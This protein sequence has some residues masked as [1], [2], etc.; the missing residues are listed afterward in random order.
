MRKFTNLKASVAPMVLGI[1]MVSAPAFAQDQDAQEADAVEQNTIIVTGSRISNPN[2]EL[3]SPVGVVTSEELELRQTNTAEQFLRELPSAIPSVGSAVN[4][5][6]GGSFFVN[7]RG[8]GSVRNLVLLDGRRFVP[9]DTTGRVDLNN[10]PLAVIERTDVLTGGATT[11]YGADAI[12]G[13]VNFITKRD[14]AGIE[15]NASQQITEQGDGNVFRTDL[16]IGANFDD[17]RGNVVLSVGYQDQDPV[18]QGDRSFGADNVGSFTGRASGSSNAV[19]ANI[20]F[21]ALRDPTSVCDMAL[22][23]VA[24]NCPLVV[25]SVNPANNGRRTTYNGFGFTPNIARQ[26]NQTGTDLEASFNP[27]PFNF[28]PFNLYQTPFE[29]FNIFGSARYEINENVELYS[30]AVFSKNTVA[31]KIAPGGSFFNVYQLNLN[32]P[33]IP[34]A[35]AQRFGNGLG[36]FGAAYTAARTTPFG[37]TLADGSANP[38]YVTFSSQVRRRTVEVGTRDSEYTSTLFNLVVGARGAI[39]D[40]IN[41][42]ISAT[43]GESERIQRQSG[44]ARFNRLQNSLLSLP[45]GQCVSGSGD[46]CAPINLFGAEGNLGPQA[47]QDYV[48]NLTQ[49]VITGT[50]IATV[51]GNITGDLGFGFSETPIQFAVGGEYRAFTATRLS[52]EASQTPG[53][54]V[55]GGGAAPDINGSYDVYDAFGELSI[56]VFEGESFAESL[57]IDLGAR[58]SDYSTAGTEFTWKAGGSWEVIPG[59]TFRGNYQRSSR[60]PNIGE[61]FTPVSTGLSNLANDP[62]QG[63]VAPTGN[64]LAACLAQLPAGSPGIAAITAG[65]L[66][67]PAAGQINVTTG[68]NLNLGTETAKTWTVGVAFQPDAVPGLSVTV[69]YFNIDI[70]GAISAPTPGDAIA[71]CFNAPSAA[72]PFC[73][74]QFISRNPFTGGI[75]GDPASTKG[76]I[77]QQSNLGA[78]A[79]DGIDLSVRYKT[80]LTDMIGLALSFDGTWTNSQTFQASPTSINRECVG[81]FSVNCG[82]PQSEFSFSQRTSLTF[83]EDYTLSLRWRYLS[84]IEQEPLDIAEN[85]AAFIGN[86]PLFGDVD[87]TRIPAESYFDLSFQWDVTENVLFT[88]TAQNLFDNKPTVVGNDIGSTSFNS[89]NTYPSS[90]DALG[91]RYGASVKFSF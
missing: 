43:Y 37:P 82:S 12:S 81:F 67:P 72:N 15:L 19:P 32:N 58:Y 6:N 31:T 63:P 27:N 11:T 17:G 20:V 40:N 87:F 62:C 7:L 18:L 36:L 70:T 44:F 78:I 1:A 84:G 56:P 9:A 4:N 90:Y 29:R 24:A 8:I 61:L 57:T 75:D 51:N 35:I 86:S 25:G 16:T 23:P 28:N 46:G 50:S 83:D 91:R 10:I 73:S 34:E 88:L 38:N 45:N 22:F 41:Y 52:D 59:L 80:D 14:F 71:A 55:G 54:V 69:D 30:Q 89:G 74:Q 5:G 53:A 49:Q 79:T 48:F 42:D 39:T 65:T 3:S 85:G 66:A 2:L 60:A 13:V 21:N 64:L 77:L 68:G 47:A 26:I 76:L 33:T